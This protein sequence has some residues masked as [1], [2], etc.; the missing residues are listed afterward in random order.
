MVPIFLLQKSPEG[1]QQHTDFKNDSQAKELGIKSVVL[2]GPDS[3]CR[4]LEADGTIAKFVG[5]DFA[6]ADTVFERCLAAI[7]QAKK[8]RY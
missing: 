4:E 1:A 2:D 6:E 8:A 5:I 3:W 7:K